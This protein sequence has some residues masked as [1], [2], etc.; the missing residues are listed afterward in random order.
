MSLAIKIIAFQLLK[1]AGTGELA[2]Y[3][4]LNNLAKKYETENIFVKTSTHIITLSILI[5]ILLT[6]FSVSQIP[7]I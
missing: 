7:R 4:H 1:G 6:P 3:T 2:V 5:S